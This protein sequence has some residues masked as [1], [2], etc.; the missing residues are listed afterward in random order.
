IDLCN[1]AWTGIK[2]TPQ[3]WS[4]VHT[5]SLFTRVPGMQAL[6]TPE[7]GG[8]IEELR[9]FANVETDDDFILLV[10]WVVGAFHPRG[11]YP[12]LALCG[13][14][15]SAKSTSARFIRS[16]VDPC[17]AALRSTPRNEQDLIIA[18]SRSWCLVF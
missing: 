14:Q 6:P 7:R 3:G 2:I 13:E 11:P 10:A 8:S 16:L 9:R 18:A 12:L 17:I 4:I 5:G 1:E 15:D